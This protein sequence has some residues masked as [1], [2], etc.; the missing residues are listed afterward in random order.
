MKFIRIFV[1]R[2]ERSWI[3]HCLKIHN[4]LWERWESKM[5]DFRNNLLFLGSGEVRGRG[6]IGRTTSKYY[7]RSKVH[8]YSELSLLSNTILFNKQFISLWCT[9]ISDNVRRTDVIRQSD[10]HAIIVTRLW[11]VTR[12]EGNVK[13]ERVRENCKLANNAIV[14]FYETLRDTR[15]SPFVSKDLS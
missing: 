13:L 8:F 1:Y 14:L 6:E 5:C 11:V 9:T 2:R 3:V 12:S 4:L 7:Q 15:R 10:V